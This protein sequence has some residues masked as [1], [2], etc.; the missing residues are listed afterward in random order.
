VIGR[1]AEGTDLKLPKQKAKWKEMLITVLT[2]ANRSK[3]VHHWV[4]M[5]V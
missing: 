2:A 1:I 5:E 3:S 4:R